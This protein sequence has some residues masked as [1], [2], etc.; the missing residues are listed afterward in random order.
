VVVSPPGRRVAALS[1]VERPRLLAR[2]DEALSH[3]LMAVIG[4]PGTGKTTLLAQWSSTHDSAWLTATPGE[5]I[6]G[7][8]HDIVGTLQPAVA[9][10]GAELTMAVDGSGLP[11][12]D[13]DPARPDAL[14]A[15]LC[16]HLAEQPD[17]DI[18]LVIDDVHVLA[19]DSQAVEFLAGLVR[20]APDQLHLVLAARQELPFPTNRLVIDGLATEIDAAELAFTADEAALLFPASPSADDQAVALVQRTGGWAIATAF[21]AR[22]TSQRGTAAAGPVLDDKGR[23]FAYFTDEVIGSISADTLEAL[24]VAA[25]LPWLTTELADH[26]DLGAAGRRLADARHASIAMVPAAVDGRAVTVAPLIREILDQRAATT[27]DGDLLA[28]RV[29]RAAAWYERA[30]SNVSALRCVVSLGDVDAVADLVTRCGAEMIA[31]GQAAD[32]LD[33][34]GVVPPARRDLALGLMEAEAMQALGQSEAAL[35]RYHQLAPAQGPVPVAVAWRLGLLLYWHG[36]V[37]LARSV[38]D[39]GGMDSGAPADQAALLAWK[40]ATSWASGNRDEAEQLADESLRL[41]ATVNDERSLATA[42]TVKAMVAAVDGDRVANFSYYLKALGHAERARDLMQIV[43]IHCNCGSHYLES[44]DYEAAM[45]ELEPAIRMAD[46]GGYGMLRALSL[47]NRAEVLIAWGRL[48][49]AVADLEAAR[50]TFKRIAPDV[51]A[52]PL[53]LL[54]RV[55]AA[56][57]EDAQARAA[58]EEACRLA[59]RRDDVQGLVPALAGLAMVRLDDDPQRALELAERATAADT[60]VAHR[61]ALLALGWVALANGDKQRAAALAERVGALARTRR[62]RPALAE[63]LELAA[64]VEAEPHARLRRLHEARDLWDELSSPLNVARVDLS[65]AELMPGSE[66]VALAESAGAVCDRLGAKRM[67]GRARALVAALGSGHDAELSIQVLGGFA[68]TLRG[69]VVP[70]SAW[71]S[72]V[73]RDL[74]KMLVVNRGRPLPRELLIERLWPGESGDKA[75]NRLSVAL[76]TIRTVLDP[77]RR[78]PPDRYVVADRDSVAVDLRHMTVDVERFLTDAARGRELLA[79]GRRDQGLA[80]LRLAEATYLGGLL[81]EQPYADWAV[82]L[83]EEALTTYLTIASTLAAAEAGAGDHESAARRYL[84]MLERDPYNEHAHLGAVNTLRSAGH[85]GQA[86]RLYRNYVARMAEI[87]VEP[88]TFP[89]A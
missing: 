31:A 8:I 10:P 23:L 71:Q 26:L 55:Y 40:A 58:F 43:R 36:E 73:A 62:D 41:A 89:A 22:A 17:H 87:D 27:A 1:A 83:R 18:V 63:V 69:T 80:L 74:F 37:D 70:A 50:D 20:H 19:A 68:V 38:L 6:D 45:D 7:L 60:A 65:L 32:V 56:R 34:I 49:E 42:F 25:V 57:G 85:H 28:A 14:A 77:D 53:T 47:T 72:K 64:A 3:R 51:E 59:E 5:S 29:R 61:Q 76:S 84:R 88:V 33:A 30:G 67:A 39:R 21:A 2:L 16:Q 46:L 12:A 35:Q 66:A 9:E 79:Q 86:Q 44:G 54:G 81:E 15:A 75:N 13:S 24:E 52:Y 48:D 82:T 11:T 78:H 4:G